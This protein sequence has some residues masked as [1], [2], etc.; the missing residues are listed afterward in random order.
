MAKRS[1]GLWVDPY[2]FGTCAGQERSVIGCACGDG[3]LDERGPAANI[4]SLRRL[5]VIVAGDSAT[6]SIERRTAVRMKSI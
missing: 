1:H 3:S 2:S 5:T 4:I 6:I